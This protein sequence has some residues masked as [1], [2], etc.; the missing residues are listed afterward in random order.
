MAVDVLV[1]VRGP[2]ITLMKFA[3]EPQR[4]LQEHHHPRAAER[5]SR[6]EVTGHASHLKVMQCHLGNF[7]S[8]SVIN[9]ISNIIDQWGICIRSVEH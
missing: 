1:D 4:R 5:I 7:Y 9:F 6:K 2:V 8:K 3:Q